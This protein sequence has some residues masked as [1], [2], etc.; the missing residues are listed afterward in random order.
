MSRSR[1]TGT[2]RPKLAVR[3]PTTITGLPSP[4]RP[5]KLSKTLSL[6]VT[7]HQCSKMGFAVVFEVY[8]DGVKKGKKKKFEMRCLSKK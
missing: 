6:F 2:A 1:F 7:L 5:T 8:R 3:K 4:N